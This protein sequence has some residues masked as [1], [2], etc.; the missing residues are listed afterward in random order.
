MFRQIMLAIVA[1][2]AVACVQNRI[3]CP[4]GLDTCVAN[5][6]DTGSGGNNPFEGPAGQMVSF[7]LTT[8]FNEIAE[9]TPIRI[10]CGSQEVEGNSS[11]TFEV[12]R[13]ATCTATL[14]DSAQRTG[15]GNGSGNRPLHQSG[16]GLLWTGE[17]SLD[18]GGDS[19]TVSR[20]N[21][22]D[23]V[24]DIAEAG[25]TEIAFD[26]DWWF[27]T[28]RMDCRRTTVSSGFMNEIS[29]NEVV[30]LEGNLWQAGPI[31]G[32]ASWFVNI[33]SSFDWGAG[34][35]FERGWRITSVELGGNH[36]FATIVT[37]WGD[38]QTLDCEWK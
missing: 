36:F 5:G 31:S 18:F 30:V 23:E 22:E 29:A 10:K 38:D 25:A 26:G 17:M 9:V 33:G 24:I 20:I 7:R 8:S 37:Q 27:A 6:D 2:F 4:N 28:P 14:G 11:S 15:S 32:S 1:T 19:I 34:D 16:E 35:G 13:G 3:S 12:R 21:R